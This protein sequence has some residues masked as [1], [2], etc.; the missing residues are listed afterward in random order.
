MNVN[1]DLL[2]EI[3]IQINAGIM[4]NVN[5]SICKK[6]HLCEKDYVWNHATCNCENGKYLASIMDNSVTICDEVAES[7]DEDAD[8]EAKSSNKAK[9]YEEIKT[10]TTNFN[11]K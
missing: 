3:E 7:N 4:V 10:I 6:R 5:M 8:A 11:E 2:E 9:S 1:V